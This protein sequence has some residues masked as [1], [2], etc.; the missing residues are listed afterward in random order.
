[1]SKSRKVP[2]GDHATPLAFELA[3]KL[4]GFA[5]PPADGTT[6]TLV[7]PRVPALKN[8]I[9]LPSGDQAI[10]C[11]TET[12]SVMMP[13]ASERSCFDARSTTRSSVPPR[14]NAIDLPSGEKRGP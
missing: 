12:G 4:T 7:K 2:S 14:T 6:E 9:H 11:P 5:S 1:V 3:R 10:G 8:A 13:L